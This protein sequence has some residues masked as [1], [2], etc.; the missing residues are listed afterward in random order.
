MNGIPSIVCEYEHTVP[1]T[2]KDLKSS[3]RGKH[4]VS[5]ATERKFDWSYMAL[6]SFATFS[7]S[8]EDNRAE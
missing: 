4:V 6:S 5:V 7:F 8:P 3:Q 1:P 2:Y